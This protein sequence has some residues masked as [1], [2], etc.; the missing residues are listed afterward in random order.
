MAAVAMENALLLICASAIEIGKL[1][2]AVNVSHS[3]IRLHYVIFAFTFGYNL[4]FQVFVSLHLL[5]L[6]L[7]KA[8]LIRPIQLMAPTTQPSKTALITHMGHQNSFLIPVTLIIKLSSKLHTSIP[9]VRTLEYAIAQQAC[10]NVLM[11]SMVLH[12]S[13]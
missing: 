1:T 2:I 12:A 9:S 3:Q 5:L 4:I 10:V 7:R 6:T 11:D 13:A 8:T